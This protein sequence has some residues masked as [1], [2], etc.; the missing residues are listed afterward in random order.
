MC[1]ALLNHMA[2]FDS[3]KAKID[4]EHPSGLMKEILWPHIHFD[5]N[6]SD[7]EIDA[8]HS[9]MP[10]PN[11]EWVLQFSD[12]KTMEQLVQDWGVKSSKA[13]DHCTPCTALIKDMLHEYSKPSGPFH[14][15]LILGQ[16]KQQGFHLKWRA[17]G[18]KPL[19]YPQW[20]RTESCS[21][22]GHWACGYCLWRCPLASSYQKLPAYSSK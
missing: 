10:N 14:D 3:S 22:T 18:L 17:I 13:A 5:S 11:D 21:T 20:L 12:S 7:D 19:C 9:N 15:M 16:V 6:N 4:Q 1:R 8:S 2:E